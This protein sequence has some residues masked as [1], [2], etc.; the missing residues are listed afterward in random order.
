MDAIKKREIRLKRDLLVSDIETK[1]LKMDIKDSD[2]FKIMDVETY[3]RLRSRFTR[4]KNGTGR[5]YEVMLDG[6]NVNV[7]RKA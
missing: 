1:C 7:T 3:Q 6:N 2:S 5:V 4:L